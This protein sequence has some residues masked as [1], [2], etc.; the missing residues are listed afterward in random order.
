MTWLTPILGAIAASIAVPLLII[1]YFLKLRRRDVE[2]S[3]TFL[4][5]KAIQDLQ[6]NA[7][8]QR[9]RRNLLLFLQLLVL[10]G[11]CIALAQPQIKGQA[12]VGSRHVIL[13]DR[14]G[15]MTATDG[16][17]TGT[18]MTRLDAAKQQAVAFVESL[19][20]GGILSGKDSSDEAMV[21]TF[22][23]AAEVRQQFTSDKA[24]LRAAIN[25]IQP[26]EGPTRIEEAIRLANAHKPKRIVEGNTIEGLT[27][28]PPMT[29]HVYSDGRVP[30]ADKAKPSPEDKLEFH[31]V[32]KPDAKNIGIVGLRAARE[33]DNP[34]KLTVYV[35]LQNNQSQAR[36]ADVE[37][38]INGTTAAIKTATLAAATNEGPRLSAP[39]A[40]RTA[41]REA[42]AAD[43]ANANA[44][45]LTP[46]ATALRAGLGGVVFQLEQPEGATIQVRLRQPG[47]G[48]P[49]EDD[50]LA[51]DDR[52]FLVIPPAKKLAIAVVSG[53]R[54]SWLDLA[55]SGLPLSR[56]IK[57]DPPRFQEFVDQGKLGEFDVIVLENWLPPKGPDGKPQD[58]PPGSYLIFGGV[59]EKGL[60]LKDDGVLGNAGI[61]DW[62][63]DHP[64]LRNLM[65]DKL[66]ISE[67]RKAELLPGSSAVVLASSQLGPAII[68]ATAPGVHAVIVPFKLDKSTWPFDTSFVIFTSAAIQYLGEDVGAGSTIKD[69]QPGSVISDRLPVGADDITVKLPTGESQKLL[70]ASDGRVTFGPLV[71]TGIYEL[72]WTGPAGPT[73]RKEGATAKRG[74]A[75]NLSDPQESDIAAA[76][77]LSTASTEAAASLNASAAADKRLWPWLL[78]AALGIVMLEWFVYN[79]KVYL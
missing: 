65:L 30:D 9:L 27:A 77:K 4:W 42:E 39:E 59:P 31:R 72:S 15:S 52:A 8:F 57:I 26:T 75:A 23:T 14:S 28:G 1:L 35:S 53:E 55:L 47:M 60:G 45:N 70:P 49:P 67:S 36:Q 61:L 22:D 18:P 51:L 3:S 63:R 79:R 56:L 43:V 46:A 73:D 25:A 6:A 54:D 37:L 19:R 21:I 66:R 71:S 13:I 68:E 64:V 41:A 78:L 69:V 38:L 17:E 58:L 16:A 34:A 40:A 20:E 48:T 24:S 33:Y 11:V 50:A 44:K 5:K 2:V 74:Y 29:I 32:G 7:P 10:A 12:V 76:D 62:S